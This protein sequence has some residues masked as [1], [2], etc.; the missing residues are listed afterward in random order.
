MADTKISALANLPAASVQMND[1]LVVVD[2]NDTSMAASGTDKN[3]TI[4]DLENALGVN[5]AAIL[6]SAGWA[7]P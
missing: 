4:G 1:L 6:L 7:L 3:L 2:V 5:S